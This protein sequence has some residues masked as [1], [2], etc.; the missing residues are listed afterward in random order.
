MWRLICRLL[1][2][3]LLGIVCLLV[4]SCIWPLVKVYTSRTQLTQVA[5]KP[6]SIPISR[7][8]GFQR[9]W[10]GLFSHGPLMTLHSSQ[11]ACPADFREFRAL[12]APIQY[13]NDQYYSDNT[14]C[15]EQVSSVCQKNSSLPCTACHSRSL[16]NC[17]E[18]RPP[19]HPVL[20]PYHP[21][22][23]GCLTFWPK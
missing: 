14:V 7:F 2:G 10:C 18:A 19:V 23:S 12:P 4:W 21:V 16:A 3:A 13:H 9:L 11:L 20:C 17:V 6:P 8:C 22:P 5:F 15:Q 1:G